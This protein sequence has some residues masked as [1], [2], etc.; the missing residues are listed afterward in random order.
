MKRPTLYLLAFTV[1]AA[2]WLFTQRPC[3][4]MSTGYFL[5]VLCEILL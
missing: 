1:S 5:G 3:F 4:I 2:L